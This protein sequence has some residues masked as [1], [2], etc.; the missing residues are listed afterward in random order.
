MLAIAIRW[1]PLTRDTLFHRAHAAARLVTLN[2]QAAEHRKVTTWLL[3]GFFYLFATAC[4]T[5]LL[6]SQPWFREFASWT[7]ITV[8]IIFAALVSRS[9]RRQEL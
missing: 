5:F 2:K 1:T 8:S 9:C 7:M 3:F 4:L 6:G